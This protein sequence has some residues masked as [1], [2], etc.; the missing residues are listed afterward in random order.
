MQTPVQA[1]SAAALPAPSVTVTGDLLAL[2]LFQI[3]GKASASSAWM[4]FHLDLSP[5]EHYDFSLCRSEMH[6]LLFVLLNLTF[7]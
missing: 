6:V 3:T 7:A 5:E 4:R 2:F 1:K